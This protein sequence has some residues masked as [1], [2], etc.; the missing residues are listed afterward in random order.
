LKSITIPESV[1]SI[2]SSAFYACSSLT[3]VTIPNSVTSIGSYAFYNCSKLTKTN[4]T[5]DIA[6]WCNIKFG[7]YY[8]NPMYCS[9]NFYVNDQ[10]IKDLVIPNTVDSIH[11][12]AFAGCS[13]L[14]SVTIPNSV[15]SIGSDAFYKCSG[16]TS[17]TIGNGITN[18][19][20]R[21]F[22]NCSKLTYIVC[23]AVVPPVL[24]SSNSSFSNLE[25]IYVPSESV[26][27]YK[28]ATNWS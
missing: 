26:E 19:E 3:S 28:T 16:L 10:E 15:T 22:G 13:S 8:A 2:G 11:S 1:T 17:V 9:H 25:A 6:G 7:D 18:I 14:T 21:A 24:G 23:N 20:Y 4:Y 5:G 12:C 27:A